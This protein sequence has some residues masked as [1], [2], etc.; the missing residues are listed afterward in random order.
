VRRAVALQHIA[1]EPPDLFADVLDEHGIA[2][3]AVELDEGAALP[4][5][6]EVDLGIARSRPPDHRCNRLTESNG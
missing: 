4:D 6:R 5:W 1:C 3:E 2:L